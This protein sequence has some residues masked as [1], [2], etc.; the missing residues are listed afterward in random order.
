MDV[1]VRDGGYTS[2]AVATALLASVTLVLGVATAEWTISR[3]ADIQDVADS[4]ALA[5]SNVVARYCTVAQ[6]AD[7]C[8][9]SLGLLG[10]SVLGSGLVLAAVPGARG[11]S[12]E[13]LE[14]GKAILDAR[15]TFAREA[16]KALRDLEVLLPGIAMANS[17]SCVRANE[18]DGITYTGAAFPLPLT[19]QSDF[20]TL[21]NELNADEVCADAERLQEVTSTIEDAARR[22]MDAKMRAWIA[23]CVDDPRCMR[24]RAQDL[25]GLSGAQNP[26]FSDAGT[27]TFGVAIQRTRAYYAQRLAREAPRGQD[28]ESVTDSLARKAFYEYALQEVQAA[29]YR[30]GTDGTV[31]LFLPHLACTSDEV[32]QTWLYTQESWPCTQE[33]EGR[34]LHST[35]ACPGATGD[36]AGV[37]SLAAVDTGS[38]RKC[39]ECGMDVSDLGGVARISTRAS[40]GYEYYWQIV[41]DESL[42]YREAQNERAR[43]ERQAKEIAQEGSDA[44]EAALEGLRVPRPRIC[45]PGAWGCVAVVARTSRKISPTQL[46]NALLQGGSLP[47]GVAVS[48]AALAPDEKTDGNTILSHLF[49]GMTEGRASRAGQALGKV[50]DLWGHLLG[51]YGHAYRDVGDIV[52]SFLGGVDGVF[53]GTVGSWLQR[54][55]TQIVE[56][57]G[58]EPTDMRMRKPV[59]VQTGDVLEKVGFDQ[60]GA[61][62]QFVNALPSNASW[63]EIARSFGVYV[64]DEVIQRVSLGTISLPGTN[65]PISLIVDL[66]NGGGLL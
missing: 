9:V 54:R 34:T 1:F 58:L 55:L 64:W 28:I 5:G 11:A 44:F 15:N 14:M 50:T 38:V 3:A 65:A 4:A 33:A 20:S 22:S 26:S 35:L 43:A 24:S 47:P 45:P 29:W 49:D 39:A 37:D 13:A 62:R 19:S 41:V 53:G 21:E 31:D 17:W 60:Q 23:D 63:Q 56:A 52:G 25:A 27:W 59:L 46:S 32:R 16:T 61:L 30:E 2:V 36:A 48:A 57:L 6:V 18:R 8:I 40:N 51:A 12:G 42:S 10:M 66:T 7:A